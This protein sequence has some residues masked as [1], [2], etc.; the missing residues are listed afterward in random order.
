MTRTLLIALGLALATPAFAGKVSPKPPA[1]AV[2]IVAEASADRSAVLDTLS[3]ELD[4]AR[5]PDRPW[6]QLYRAEQRRIAGDLA[7][8]TADFQAVVD[9][10]DDTPLFDEARLGL[11]LT[12]LQADPDDVDAQAVVL[13]PVSGGPLPTLHASRAAWQAVLVGGDTAA[14]QAERALSLSRTDAALHARLEARLAPVLERVPDAEPPGTVRGALARGDREA[15]RALVDAATPA[16]LLAA[17][18]GA[19]QVDGRIG[20]LLPLSGRFATV[21]GQLQQAVRLGWQAGGREDEPVWI[22]SGGTPDT[23]VAALQTLVIDHGVVGVV[24]PLLSD[25]SPAV[26]TAAAELGVPL[27]SMSQA[28]T[29]TGDSPWIFQTWMTPEAQI[30][31]LA[32]EAV[33]R[34][35]RTRFLVLV[36]DTAYG[37][38]AADAFTAEVTARGG[39]VVTRR[40]YATDANDFRPLA[41]ELAPKPDDETPPEIAFD[42]V[43]LPD[44][45]RRATLVASA[46]AVQEVPLGTYLP[47]EEQGQTAIILGLSGWNA[48]DLVAAG[49]PYFQKGVFTD[50]F[51]PPPPTEAFRWYPLPGWSE[52]VATFREATGRTPNALEALASEAGRFAAAAS[53]EAPHRAAYRDAL[54]SLSLDPGVTGATAFDPATR[55]LAHR[56]RIVSVRRDG[57]SPAEE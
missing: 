43:F 8:A 54:L 7:G 52:W 46:L 45:A 38:T 41:Q 56:I 6:W 44:K 34:R 5:K 25:A 48:Y 53:L 27:L 32:E 30:A 40:A 51:V 37:T 29:D 20:V 28:L 11:A 13:A 35:E 50:V 18:D 17:L 15:A 55:T 4:G 36:P 19:P 39:E 21:G 42:A 31:A 57:F 1:E 14:E 10:G 3:A 33:V 16:R 49:G 24:G 26:V 23:A 47:Y 12:A 22:D 9:E 2:Q